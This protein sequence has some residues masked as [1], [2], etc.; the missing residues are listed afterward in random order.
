VIVDRGLR[1][2]RKVEVVRPGGVRIVS[3]GSRGF[4]ER[5]VRPGFVARTYVVGGRTDVRVYRERTFGRVHYFTYVPRVY[6]HPA[7]YAWAYRPWGAPVVFAWGFGPSRWYAYQ[8]VYFAPEPVYPTAALWLTDYLL[9]ENLR[10]AYE[11][12]L[13]ANG[14]VEPEPAPSNGT[15]ALSPEIKR[16]IAEEVQQQ[17][18]AERAMAERSAAGVPQPAEIDT[19]PQALDPKQRIFVV[20]TG[21]DLGAGPQSCSLTPGD[22]IERTSRVVSDDGKVPVS[23]V[24]SKDGDCPVEFSAAMDVSTLQEMHNQFREQ[25]AAGMDKLST[26]QGKGLPTGPAAN[27]RVIAGGQAE[28]SADASALLKQQS[29]EA[30]KTEAEVKLPPAGTQP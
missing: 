13:A 15:A 23:V 16:Q 1:G 14:G 7:F 2:E 10:I 28:A 30:D 12:R 24:T 21:V 27:P 29:A 5:P 19:L 8:G 11:N 22:I 25:I 20:A 6:Y 18:A 9:A 26:T 4:V 17:I 3:V